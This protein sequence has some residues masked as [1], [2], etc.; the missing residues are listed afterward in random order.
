MKLTRTQATA[1]DFN[2]LYEINELSIKEHVI[3]A[4]GPWDS[5][6]QIKNFSESTVFQDHEIISLKCSPVG[7]INIER[8]KNSIHLNRICILPAYQSKGIGTYLIKELLSESK[9]NYPVSLQVFHSNPAKNLYTR[10]GFKEYK[11]SKTH[12]YLKYQPIS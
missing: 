1:E 7:F 12:I 3:A 10:L 11:Q 5:E 9:K 6:F 4:F 8:R 2:L